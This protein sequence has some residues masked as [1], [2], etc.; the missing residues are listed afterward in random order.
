MLLSIMALLVTLAGCASIQ[1]AEDR[2]TLTFLQV[3]ASSDSFKGQ[4]GGL[5]R[6]SIGGPPA[7][8][9]HEDQNLTVAARS[10]RMSGIRHDSVTKPFIVLQREFLDPATLPPET[11]VTVT[12]EVSGSITLPLDETDYAY[13]YMRPRLY[14]GLSGTTF[15][16]LGRISW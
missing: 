4:F 2:Q 13:L 1:E 15:G 16:G 3:N 9:Q 14:W 5:R 11:R 8:R 12:G 6:H 10:N 7:G